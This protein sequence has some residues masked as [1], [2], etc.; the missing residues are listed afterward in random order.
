M[1]AKNMTTSEA[2]SRPVGRPRTFS[3]DAVFAA[4]A[5]AV[6]TQGF[7]GMAIDNVAEELGC[8]GP[9]LVGRF[10]S[11]Q[12]LLRAYL[13][14]ANAESARR[15]REVRAAYIS[16]L[17][18]LRARFHTLA[19]DRLDPPTQS[20]NHMSIL[21]LHIAAWNDPVLQSLE[22]QRR[23][24]FEAE[25]TLLLEE[26]QAAGELSPCDPHRLGKTLFAAVVGTALQWTC[27]RQ[28]AIEDSL[29]EVIDEVVKPYRTV[30]GSEG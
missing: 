10:G 26:A 2:P 9:A 23:T 30:H 28:G 25:L 3:D 14:W 5:R 6:S 22:R 27:D 8:T 11:R 13:E 17:A 21:V 24:M 29:V 7:S 16:P 19:D 18:A 4:T 12:G 15:F 1:V 20:A